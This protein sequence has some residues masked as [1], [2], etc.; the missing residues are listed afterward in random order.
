[1]DLWRRR[2]RDRPVSELNNEE[3]IALKT[4]LEGSVDR[5]ESAMHWFT[6]LVA[7]GLIVEYREPF[8]KF[9][10]NSHQRR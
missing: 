1:M 6:A 7:V 2:R 8:L 3:I 9:I 10:E 5:F 4:S